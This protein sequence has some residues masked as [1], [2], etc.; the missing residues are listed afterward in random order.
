MDIIF[1]I[2]WIKE[3]YDWIEKPKFLKEF[4][5]HET[6]LPGLK[7]F[8]YWRLFDTAYCVTDRECIPEMFC[9]NGTCQDGKFDHFSTRLIFS[10]LLHLLNRKTHIFSRSNSQRR[11]VF[12][13]RPVHPTVA[14]QLLCSAWNTATGGPEWS[15]FPDA[16]GRPDESLPVQ[17]RFC[18]IQKFLPWE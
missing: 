18:R 7:K 15:R 14:Q 6:E 1:K 17:A 4:G 2:I 16:A 13:Q 9:Q 3:G 10:F 12:M 8:V 5:S 11:R